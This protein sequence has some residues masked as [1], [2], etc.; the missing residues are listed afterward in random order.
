M[1]SNQTLLRFQLQYRGVPVMFKLHVCRTELWVWIRVDVVLASLSGLARGV[2][3]GV[4]QDDGF[5]HGSAP[6]R[7]S[8]SSI[9]RIDGGGFWL[10]CR[11]AFPENYP[12][13]IWAKLFTSN[14]SQCL[15][16]RALLRWYSGESPLVRH[17][18]T[19]QT[20]GAGE[21]SDA[22]CSFNGTVEWGGFGRHARYSS[23]VF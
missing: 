20:K 18:V 21:C 8:F 15:Y 5:E 22:A 23:Y 10:F 3:D 13:H 17:G 19:R 7:Y 4:A 12:V 14:P 16:I 1:T 6:C 11:I 2:A 9:L